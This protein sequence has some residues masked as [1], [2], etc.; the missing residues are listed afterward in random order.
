MLHRLRA[1]ELRL[2]PE[3]TEKLEALF[4]P[5]EM[6]ATKA[7]LQG[8]NGTV[9]TNDLNNPTAAQI[10]VGATHYFVGD[11]QYAVELLS[12]F[13]EY[14]CATVFDDQWKAILEERFKNRF[15]IDTRTVFEHDPAHFDI[16]KLSK[17]ANDLPVGYSIKPI[18]LSFLENAELHSL[19]PV[20]GPQYKNAQDFLARGLG[21]CVL[22]DG[23]DDKNE[24]EA[25]NCE[26]TQAQMVGAAAS[27][28]NY[29]DGIEVDIC[30]DGAH[31]QKGLAT[32]VCATLILHCLEQ[33]LFP[34]WDAANESSVKLAQKLGYK[35]AGVYDSYFI[36]RFFEQD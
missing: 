28:N 14:M 2:Q 15:S 11:C 30:I 26:P 24:G 20:T 1:R 29:D 17:L 10:Q 22:F 21:Y 9:W 32:A 23:K 34:Y 3:L 13:N 35:K 12:N 31:R 8:H 4:A 19:I 25:A 7:C 33:G 27:H 6:H 36:Y 5:T 16:A 18:D